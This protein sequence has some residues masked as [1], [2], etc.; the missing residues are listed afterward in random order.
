[1]LKPIPPMKTRQEIPNF[2][3]SDG[4]LSVGVEVGVKTGDFSYEIL[5]KWARCSKFYLVDIW[6]QQKNYIDGANVNDRRQDQLFN[7]TQARLKPF[8]NKLQY[9]RMFSSE[10]SKLIPDSSVDFVYVDARHDF[11]GAY[12]D[13]TLY[14]PKIRR[15]GILAGHD[16]KFASETDAKDDWSLCMNGTRHPGAVKGAVLQFAQ[17]TGTQVVVTYGEAWPSW[18][19][20][21]P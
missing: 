19:I 3:Q 16:F 7:I 5:S 13:I 12:E 20:R 21:K 8:E 6:R 10:A 17:E 2:L 14:W 9:L 4:G 11:C 18:L 1:M 15:G